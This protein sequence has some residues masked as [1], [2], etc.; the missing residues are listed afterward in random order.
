M[1][2]TR[3]STRRSTRHSTRRSTIGLEY[4]INKLPD[5]STYEI[6]LLHD[7]LE[8]VCKYIEDTDAAMDLLPSIINDGTLVETILAI[9]AIEAAAYMD[10]DPD[11]DDDESMTACNAVD[12]IIAADTDATEIADVIEEIDF[13]FSMNDLLK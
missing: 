13:E 1:C 2:S 11:I 5:F 6:K 12:A 8:T 7:D 10:I 4:C 9:D 3:R